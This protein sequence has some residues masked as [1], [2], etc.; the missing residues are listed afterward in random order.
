MILY[1]INI[2]RL[3]LR[4]WGCRLGTKTVQYSFVICIISQYFSFVKRFVLKNTIYC[5]FICFIRKCIYNIYDFD[6]LHTMYYLIDKLQ[7]II[8][9][10]IKRY[11]T[12]LER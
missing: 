1:C 6:T 5:V 4:H 9:N 2:Y 11:L 8:Y 7:E 10:N 3:I 12:I